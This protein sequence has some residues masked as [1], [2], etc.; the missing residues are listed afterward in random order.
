VDNVDQEH[1]WRQLKETYGQ[2]TDDELSAVARR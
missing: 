2:M 1:E